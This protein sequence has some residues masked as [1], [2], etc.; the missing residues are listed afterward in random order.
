MKAFAITIV[1]SYD[2]AAEAF[3]FRDENP[4]LVSRIL[5]HVKKLNTDLT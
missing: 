5:I 3:K 1:F 4:D 2:R